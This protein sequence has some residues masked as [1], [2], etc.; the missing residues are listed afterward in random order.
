LDVFEHEHQRRDVGEPSDHSEHQLQDARWAAVV[1][2]GSRSGILELGNEPRDLVAGAAQHRVQISGLELGGK[3]ADHLD[4]RRKRDASAI[5]L[6]AAT[7]ERPHTGLACLAD[8]VV[9]QP[10]LAHAG[11]TADEHRRLLS[12]DG[13]VKRVAQQPQ[14]R[15]ASHQDG[16]HKTRRHARMI[17]DPGAPPECQRT[18][19]VS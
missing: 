4:Q 14:L 8:Q 12:G 9:H 2:R 5:E 3:R 18:Y 17:P 16:A 19:E 10:R 15:L 11:L 1:A 7:D 13:A 6:D